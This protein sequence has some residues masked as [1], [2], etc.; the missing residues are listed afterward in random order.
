LLHGRSHFSIGV[1]LLGLGT[2]IGGEGLGVL[3]VQGPSWTNLISPFPAN[4]LLQDAF[5]RRQLPLY[6]FPSVPQTGGSIL[7]GHV[8]IMQGARD[9]EGDEVVTLQG[10]L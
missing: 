6:V 4:L 3:S 5:M 10:P 9:G 8:K 1:L 2:G 7:G